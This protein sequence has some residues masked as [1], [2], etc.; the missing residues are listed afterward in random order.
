MLSRDSRD[1]LRVT[2]T[3]WNGPVKIGPEFRTRPREVWSGSKDDAVKFEYL[4]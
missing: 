4:K 1:G 2:P 3:G